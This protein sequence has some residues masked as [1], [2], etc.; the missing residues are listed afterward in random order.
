MNI[1]RFNLKNDVVEAITSFAKVHQY[2]SNKDYKHYWSIWCEENSDIVRDEI[3]RLYNIGYRGDALDKMYK[4]GRYYFRKKN[5]SCVVEPK[6]RREYISMSATMINAMD[7]HI[8]RAVLGDDFTP[9]NGYDMFCESNVDLL[10]LEICSLT[11][12]TID[13]KSVI[14]KIKKTYKNRYFIYNKQWSE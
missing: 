10:A 13:K 8:S 1:Y 5:L 7:E 12:D 6:K 2:D 11:K 9:A 14:S 4:S 3:E